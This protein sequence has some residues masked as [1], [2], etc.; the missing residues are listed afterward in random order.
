MNNHDSYRRRVNALAIVASAAPTCSSTR[1]RLP[2]PHEPEADR[3]RFESAMAGATWT[4][5]LEGDRAQP[6]AA[7]AARDEWLA[8]AVG[9]ALVVADH[10]TAQ[11]LEL[12]GVPVLEI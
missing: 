5:I 3:A 1:R 8:S 4:V 9:G 2:T 12:A 7:V 11:R 6:G 10:V